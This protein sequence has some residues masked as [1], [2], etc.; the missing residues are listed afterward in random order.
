[1]KKIFTGIAIIMAAVI[2][3]GMQASAEEK[4]AGVWKTIADEGADKGKAKSYLDITADASGAY[5][6]R[7][8]KLL[9]KPQDTKCDKCVGALKDKPLIGMAIFSNMKKTGKVDKDFGDEYAG[10]QIMDPDNGK[11]YRCKLWVKGDTMVVRGYLAFFYRTQRW[12]RV[13]E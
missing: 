9:L 13:K 12:Y 10:G 4:L 11:F 6:A 5:T 1:M 2:F 8:K 7:I 3:F